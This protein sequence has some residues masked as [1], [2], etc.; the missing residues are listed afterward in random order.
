MKLQTKTCNNTSKF[1]S[2][3]FV[4]INPG[5]HFF[6]S[7]HLLT[8]KPKEDRNEIRSGQSVSGWSEIPLTHHSDTTSTCDLLTQPSPP[9]HPRTHTEQKLL[10]GKG[11]YSSPKYTVI[12]NFYLRIL[13]KSLRAEFYNKYCPLSSNVY[14]LE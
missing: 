7:P 10:W 3:R 4:T 5:G 1:R 11:Q 2:N 6:L 9:G 14:W 13:N 8:T 12:S